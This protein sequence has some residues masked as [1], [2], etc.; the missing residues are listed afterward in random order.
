MYD[1]QERASNSWIIGLGGNHSG[2]APGSI[3]TPMQG[4]GVVEP[5][6]ANQGS[7]DDNS[8]DLLLQKMGYAPKLHRGLGAFMNFA[9]GFTEV[10][11]LASLAV[12]LSS[13]YTRL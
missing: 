13:V 5:T 3:I 7:D 9:F 1:G 6:G 4:P 2:R 8:G 12:R 11:V 10:A